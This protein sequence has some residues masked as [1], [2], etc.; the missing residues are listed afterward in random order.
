MRLKIS[1]CTEYSYDQPPAYALQRLRLVPQ[2]GHAQTVFG[3]SLAIEGAREEVRFDDQFGN[4]TRLVSVEGEPH[5]ISI[6][7]AG[8]VETSDKSGLSGPHRGFAPLWLF[9]APT[10]LTRIREKA[11]PR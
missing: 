4:D 6:V 7:A 8:E 9:T 1:H 2:S 11:F 3:W 5:R 10:T